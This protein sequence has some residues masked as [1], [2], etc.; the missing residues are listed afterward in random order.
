MAE[1]HVFGQLVGGTGFSNS[2]LSCKWTLRQGTNWNIVEGLTEGITQQDD[3]QAG[4]FSYWCHPLD[5]HFLTSGI[6]GWPKLELE[7]WQQNV[8]GKSSLAGYG[9]VHLPSQPGFQRLECHTWKPVGDYRDQLYSLFTSGSLVLSNSNL[10]HDGSDRHQ[11][12]T[13]ASGIVVLELYTVI[14]N[15]DRFGIQMSQCTR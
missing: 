10:V 12:Q 11:L 3:P 5:I 4:N 1:V 9:F 6:Q 15:F 2:R 7:V 14:K 8:Y 13:Q